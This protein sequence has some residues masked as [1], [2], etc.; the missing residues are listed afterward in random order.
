MISEGYVDKDND[1]GGGVFYLFKKDKTGWKK[2]YEF[3][4]W[5]S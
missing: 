4:K 2:I 3:Q 1:L 5:K